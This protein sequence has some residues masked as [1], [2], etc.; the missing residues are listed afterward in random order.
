[1]KT[2]AIVTIKNPDGAATVLRVISERLGDRERF[3]NGV[4]LLTPGEE[5]DFIVHDGQSLR[6]EKGEPVA[7]AETPAGEATNSTEA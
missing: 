5:Q 7:A 3:E 2:T 1:M 4:D 6:V